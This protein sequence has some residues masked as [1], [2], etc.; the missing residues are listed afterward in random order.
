M[1]TRKPGPRKRTGLSVREYAKHRREL[2]LVG[3]NPSAVQKALASGLA[4]PSASD[5]KR[6]LAELQPN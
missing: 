1:A 4:D 6:L 3:T 2:G 5:A